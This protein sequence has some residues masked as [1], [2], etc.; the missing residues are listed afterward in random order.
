MTFKPFLIFFLACRV[1]WIINSRTRI[2]CFSSRRYMVGELLEKEE[3]VNLNPWANKHLNPPKPL[4]SCLCLIPAPSH[5][6][7]L[8]TDIQI[9]PRQHTACCILLQHPSFG[10]FTSPDHTSRYLNKQRAPAARAT[11]CFCNRRKRCAGR[12]GGGV[13]ALRQG[14][15]PLFS[16]RSWDSFCKTLSV[17]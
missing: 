2:M 12:P 7:H 15:V 5:H 14:K 3:D 8:L 16:A 9:K 6:V 1:S 17:L 13:P 10:H 11:V 4:S